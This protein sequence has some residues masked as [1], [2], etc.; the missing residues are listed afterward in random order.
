MAEQWYQALKKTILFL[1]QHPLIGRERADLKPTPSIRQRISTL[2]DFLFCAGGQADR[3]VAGATWQ[4]EPC[5]VGNGVL[6]W[7]TC[8]ARKL[9]FMTTDFNRVHH[10]HPTGAELP[11]D[12]RS[13]FF[14]TRLRP[15]RIAN[16]FYFS[17]API[18]VSANFDTRALAGAST[19]RNQ[20]I[21]KT[22]HAS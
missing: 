15:F 14:A 19:L 1:Q 17:E 8:P 6:R 5:G 20:V 4:H 11:E 2:A 9:H 18:I 10:R 16:R 13:G 21:R 3:S 22:A 7:V 12:S